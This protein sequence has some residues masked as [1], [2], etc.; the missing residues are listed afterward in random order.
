MDSMNAFGVSKK[1]LAM[2]LYGLLIDEDAIDLEEY[3]TEPFIERFE[4]VLK[5]YGLFLKSSVIE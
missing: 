2:Q 1:S 5:D 4:E 3:G